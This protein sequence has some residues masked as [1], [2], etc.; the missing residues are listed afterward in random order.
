MRTQERFVWATPFEFHFDAPRS[1]CLSICLP[2]SAN[3][4]V[5]LSLSL[6]LKIPLQC[7]LLMWGLFLII[8]C[9]NK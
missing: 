6:S 4:A 5:C 9:P 2:V 3:L 7:L 8:I 1:V